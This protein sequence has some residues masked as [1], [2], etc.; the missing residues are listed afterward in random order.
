[1]NWESLG[2]VFVRVLRSWRYSA[3]VWA[4]RGRP[5]AP[6]GGPWELQDPFLMNFGG[7]SGSLGAPFFHQDRVLDP[8]FSMSVFAM[9]L[10]GVFND[11]G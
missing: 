5:L 7:P 11:F 9:V 4:T 10:D 1:M 6:Q 3:E 8:C 2:I